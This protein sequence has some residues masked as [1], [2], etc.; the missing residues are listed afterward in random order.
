MDKIF[1]DSN[2]I[3]NWILIKKAQE[4]NQ[5]LRK[6]KL[7]RERFKRFSYSY[8]LIEGLREISNYETLISPLVIAEVY[9]VVYNEVLSLKLYRLGIPLT[10][11]SKLKNK[12]KLTEEE[13]FEIWEAVTKNIKE[14]RKS[15]KIVNDEVDE[16]IYPKLLLDYNLRPHDAVLLTTAIINGCAWFITNDKEIV[17]L[18]RRKLFKDVLLTTPEL[19]QNFLTV[20]KG[21]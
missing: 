8:T 17:N 18:K 15:V 12:H 13:K 1:L 4:G 3:A 14:L 19:P 6:D 2:V 20:S 10:L 16:E 5:E 21:E 9:H 7:L 11:W